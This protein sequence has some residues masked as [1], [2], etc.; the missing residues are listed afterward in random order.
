MGSLSPGPERAGTIPMR[1]YTSSCA[2]TVRHLAACESGLGRAQS[3]P[4]RLSCRALDSS[5]LLSS[6]ASRDSDLQGPRDEYENLGIL[7]KGHLDVVGSGHR[8]NCLKTLTHSW[9]VS[10]F[11]FTNETRQQQDQCG[12]G[13]AWAYLQG[14]W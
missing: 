13:K 3:Y 12:A 1:L 8:G 2:L 7:I 14:T 10:V 9:G 4:G 6:E 11:P 5:N